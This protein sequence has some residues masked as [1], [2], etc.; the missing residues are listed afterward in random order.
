MARPR[1]AAALKIGVVVTSLAWLLVVLIAS[2]DE[3]NRLSEALKHMWS[4]ST[5]DGP[6]LKN[7]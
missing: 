1:L 6:A 4:Q 5:S 3:P 2:N 7:D